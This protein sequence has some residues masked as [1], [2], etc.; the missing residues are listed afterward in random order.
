MVNL[1]FQNKP[2]DP[3]HYIKSPES[4]TNLAEKANLYNEKGREKILKIILNCVSTL[5]DDSFIFSVQS[6]FIGIVQ[7]LIG[8]GKNASSCLALQILDVVALRGASLSRR[9]EWNM[10]YSSFYLHD[11]YENLKFLLRDEVH[12]S[13][14]VKSI[15]SRIIIASEKCCALEIDDLKL[16]NNLL[17]T[18]LKVFETSLREGTYNKAKSDNDNT[19]LSILRAI[20]ILCILPE[21]ASMISMN[22]IQQYAIS[23]LACDSAIIVSS[24]L[25]LLT[26][27]CLKSKQVV[28]SLISKYSIFDIIDSILPGGEKTEELKH[29]DSIDIEMLREQ[30]ASLSTTIK[31][32][33]PQW[34]LFSERFSKPTVQK[35]HLSIVSSP[36]VITSALNLANCLALSSYSV[37]QPMVEQHSLLMKLIWL[38][39]VT[40]LS[41]CLIRCFDESEP[42]WQPKPVMATWRSISCQMLSHMCQ[43]GTAEQLNRMHQ[44][45]GESALAERMNEESDAVA[46]IHSLYGLLNLL[47]RLKTAT[48][49]RAQKVYVECLKRMEEDGI[50]DSIDALLHHPVNDIKFKAN[51]FLNVCL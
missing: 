49:R 23:F 45:G 48:T 36:S 19:V 37:I 22:L 21:N 9:Q 26:E 39:S 51:Q 32:P 20:S 8:K 47:Y 40:T 7:A 38:S 11:T 46:V 29:N 12:S 50:E 43:W 6:G 1:K 5:D 2:F 35:L 33:Y 31:V 30:L 17:T 25:Q 34:N 41:P 44:M 3:S 27:M 16:F 18:H 13:F 10:F 15:V 4:L 24:V 14:D 42:G 28:E